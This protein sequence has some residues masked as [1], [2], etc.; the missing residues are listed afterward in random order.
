M[1][2][3]FLLLFIILGLRQYGWVIMFT[4]QRLN[5]EH[6]NNYDHSRKI[7]KS[8]YYEN[9]DNFHQWLVGFTDGDGS[10]T[11]YRSKDGKWTLL[12][13]KYL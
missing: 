4:R 12:N 13:S 10:F 9:K 5:V 7:N 2:R 8:K 11:I 1:Y 3:I 6:P